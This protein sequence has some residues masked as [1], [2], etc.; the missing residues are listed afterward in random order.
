ML[1][2]FKGDDTGGTIGKRLALTIDSTIPL[3]GCEVVFNFCGVIRSWKNVTS[4][5]EV[6]VFFSHNET[7]NFPVGVGKASLTLVDASGK[8]RTLTNSLP[9]KVTTNVAECY[10]TEAQSATIYVRTVVAWSDISSKPFTG[11]TIT[12]KTDDD[13]LAAVGTIIEQLGG[14]VNA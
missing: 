3:A 11:Q 6:E 9:I 5:Q 14:T 4:G 8:R 13:M 1:T 2:V 10:G 7:R 12:L